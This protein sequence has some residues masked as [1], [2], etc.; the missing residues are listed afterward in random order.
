MNKKVEELKERIVENE[1][2]E[3]SL[4]SSQNQ[5]NSLHSVNMSYASADI[6]KHPIHFHLFGSPH[7]L[8]SAA[9]TSAETCIQCRRAPQHYPIFGEQLHCLQLMPQQQAPPLA[10]PPLPL[11]AALFTVTFYSVCNC[12]ASTVLATAIPS[13]R[14]SVCLSV[15]PS[16]CLSHA[17]IV[18]KRRHIARC[19]FHRWIAKCVSFCKN[20][21]IFP[22][23]DPFPQKFWLSDLPTPEGC[24]F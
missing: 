16:V 24:E 15:P 23:D 22:R 1:T 2:N 21:K 11:L 19:S 10:P 18:S 6:A 7:L 13:V 14:P 8:H 9:R 12:I 17:A 4:H 20:Q 5:H 3:T